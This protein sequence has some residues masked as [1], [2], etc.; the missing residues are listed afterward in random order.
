[1]K[2]GMR[3]SAWA[4]GTLAGKRR[5]EVLT[6][7]RIGLIAVEGDEDAAVKAMVITNRS[8]GDAASVALLGVDQL[9]QHAE[10]LDCALPRRRFSSSPALHTRVVELSTWARSRYG[11]EI[12]D[13]A[14][15]VR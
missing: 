10:Y 15:G 1:M 13:A 12:L 4:V 3:V 8:P 6:A 7:D 11:S 14:L 9:V 5:T 2:T